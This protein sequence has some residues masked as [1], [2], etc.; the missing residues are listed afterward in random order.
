MRS[1][2][3]LDQLSRLLKHYQTA[4]PPRP[5]EKASIAYRIR[6]ALLRWSNNWPRL[7]FAQRWNRSLQT[8]LDGANNVAEQASGWYIKERY[9]TMRTY[10]QRTSV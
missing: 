5:G 6:L 4:S 9:R 2:D 1:P 10:K 8:S 7:I 3:G